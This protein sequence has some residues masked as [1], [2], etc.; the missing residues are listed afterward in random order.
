VIR[1][2]EPRS[3]EAISNRDNEIASAHPST[4]LRF[5]QDASR[6]DLPQVEMIEP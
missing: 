3:G 1:H 4:A 2:C 6:N 5:A